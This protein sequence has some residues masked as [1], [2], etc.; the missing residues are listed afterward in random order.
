[1][2]TVK[3]DRH[4]KLGLFSHIKY[5]KRFILTSDASHCDFYRTNAH[6]KYEIQ[7]RK[8]KRK[9]EV[10]SS[11]DEQ[12]LANPKLCTSTL[13]PRTSRC[14]AINVG[15]QEF[16]MLDF[17]VEKLFSQKLQMPLFV[18]IFGIEFTE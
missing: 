14:T 10:Q 4:C 18:I 12:R 6:F 8:Y 9:R 15:S 7:P 3:M 1:M 5:R 17:T 11:K 2:L 13:V 16:R